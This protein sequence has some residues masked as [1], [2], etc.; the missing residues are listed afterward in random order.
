[1]S[2]I[3]ILREMFKEEVTVS[4]K[5]ELEGKRERRSVILYEPQGNY[6]IKINGMP[7]SD[8]VIVIKADTFSG[9]REVFVGSKGE[10][11]RADFIIIAD[12]STEK[13]ILYIEMK[14][15]R[16][17]AKSIINQLKGAHCFVTYCREIGQ[18]FWNQHNFL[19]DYSCRF[20]SIQKIS[21]AK[22]TTR[23]STKTI[24]DQPDKMLRLYHSAN[25]QFNSLI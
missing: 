3:A 7:K 17:N 11:K 15:G 20:V 1:M 21:I 18:S 12:T 24:H 10:C 13:I 25:F 14:A 16:D 23:P 9:P 5:E 4:L 8:E 6:S 19:K 2:D 22:K